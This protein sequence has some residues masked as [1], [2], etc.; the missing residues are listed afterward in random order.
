MPK[1]L[2]PLGP[3]PLVAWSL[4]AL[5][6]CPAIDG[7]VVAAPVGMQ[8]LMRRALGGVA[9]DGLVV[10]EGGSSRQRSVQKAL[11]VVPDDATRILVHD[12]ARP[13]M[14]AAMC[15]AILD[16]L[17][18]VDGAIAASPVADTIKRATDDLLID[19]TVDRSHLWH[20][21]TPQAFHA[22][23]LRRVFAA[24]DDDMLDTATDC[25]S[26]VEEAGGRVRL[27]P[28]ASMNIKVTSPAD[29][30]L[31]ADVLRAAGR[32]LAE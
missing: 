14:T 4:L 24:A 11:H 12:A 17:D 2:V 25:S 5:A 19:G 32:L 21:Q 16:R 31:A 7:I 27:V 10:V 29:L 8:E 6:E 26:M 15:L 1:A 9:G 22:D 23:V 28:S 20:A 30:E 3:H 13:L 18:G